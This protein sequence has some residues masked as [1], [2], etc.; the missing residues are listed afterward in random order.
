FMPN[1]LLNAPLAFVCIPPMVWAAF[2][3]RRHESAT[4][5]VILSAI[6]IWGALRGHGPFM[7]ASLNESLL[8]LQCFMGVVAVMNLVLCAAAHQRNQEHEALKQVKQE[9]EKKVA[10]RTTELENRIRAQEQAE[11]VLRQLSVRLMQIQ[12]QERRTI[13]RDLH[14]STGQELVV[15]K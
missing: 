10:E 9:L 2:Q 1:A 12:D 6:A 3:L 5:V 13:A 7:R 14:D 8:F 4:V 11:A 15:L